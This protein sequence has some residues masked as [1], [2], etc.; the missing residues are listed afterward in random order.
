MKKQL[1]K[2]PHSL[3]FWGLLTT[4]WLALSSCQGSSISGTVYF[5][6]N[7]NGK[8]DADE[9]GVPFAKISVTKDGQPIAKGFTFQNG[10]FRFAAKGGTYILDID[11]SSIDFNTAL[12]QETSRPLSDGK[13]QIFEQE[14]EDPSPASL[15]L[16]A[17]AIE[18]PPADA[19]AGS[20]D[21]EGAGAGSATPKRGGATGNAT[22]N[23]ASDSNTSDNDNT[24]NAAS[25]NSND[26]DSSSNTGSATSDNK[27]SD[28]KTTLPDEMTDEGFRTTVKR[29]EKK[30]ISIP[31]KVDWEGPTKKF[32]SSLNAQ[33]CSP[34]TNCQISFA[35]ISGCRASVTLF[36]GASLAT[37][38]DIPN[39][40]INYDPNLNIVTIDDR[41][42]FGAK[43]TTIGS[44]VQPSV[45]VKTLPL[46]ISD[47]IQIPA[48]KPLEVKLRPTAT[49][50]NRDT[51]ISLGE[52][53][54]TI[55]NTDF[56]K[57]Y[58]TIDTRLK[59]R[60]EVFV[61]NETKRSWEKSELL[62]DIVSEGGPAMLVQI[63]DSCANLGDR[64][65]CTI[66]KLESEE[67]K[68]FK[69]TF[70]AENQEEVHTKV[71]ITAKL[72]L[73]NPPKEIVSDEA[74]IYLN[75]KPA[76]PEPPDDDDN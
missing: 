24:N 68:E 41:N 31:V 64:A 11:T 38:A 46:T 63:D 74:R 53:D 61:V 16:K 60:G 4:M 43:A 33:H 15:N 14:L 40:G 36:S 50:G 28:G 3:L 57:V 62:I 54:V 48:D 26:S 59:V 39:Q 69:F 44:L 23:N 49:C 67:I 8:M 73:S 27:G 20:R 12:R 58:I 25:S 18:N 47:D 19:V 10:A 72:R 30:K 21:S 51:E 65:L 70:A 5:D 45:V 66:P 35:S 6:E 42:N 1:L 71:T 9:Q 17:K 75:P 56:P 29:G 32:L 76:P 37:S 52:I 13:R 2:I 22:D 34:G 7:G 55:S